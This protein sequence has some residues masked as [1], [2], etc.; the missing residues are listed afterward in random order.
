MYKY[1]HFL[2]IYFFKKDAVTVSIRVGGIDRHLLARGHST[3]NPTIK[4]GY[5]LHEAADTFLC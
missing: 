3:G 5:V 1:G 2:F 4:A